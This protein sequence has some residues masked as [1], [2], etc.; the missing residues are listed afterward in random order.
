MKRIILL[1]ILLFAGTAWAGEA[2]EM[3]IPG[4]PDFI[5]QEKARFEKD[6]LIRQWAASGEIC[7]VLGHKF[8]EPFKVYDKRSKP[9]FDFKWHRTC[10]MCGKVETKVEEWR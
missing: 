1:A 10:L 9:E 4:S 8:G 3:P 2:I 5:V 6:R 7:R